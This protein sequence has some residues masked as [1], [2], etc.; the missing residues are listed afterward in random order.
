MVQVHGGE[1]LSLGRGGPLPPRPTGKARWGPTPPL[2]LPRPAWAGFGGHP[3]PFEG[4]DRLSRELPSM[5]LREPLPCP[6]AGFGYYTVF[7]RSGPP[8]PGRWRASDAAAV[9]PRRDPL[10]AALRRSP[11]YDA[12]CVSRLAPSVPTLHRGAFLRVLRALR[13]EAARAG[14]GLG[15]RSTPRPPPRRSSAGSCNKK[16][17]R[18]VIINI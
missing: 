3:N 10:P 9:S 6:I 4:E 13:G 12:P 8:G 14:A 5:S 15:G 2:G 18:G 1:T 17:L 7:H 11:Q 16:S